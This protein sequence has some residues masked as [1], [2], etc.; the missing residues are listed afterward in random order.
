MIKVYKNFLSKEE[1]ENVREYFEFCFFRKKDTRPRPCP[2]IEGARVIYG[3]PVAD[4]FLCSKKHIVEK[5]FNKELLPTYSYTRMYYNGQALPKHKDRPACEISLT[6][7]IWQDL[8]WPIF[9]D[10]KPYSAKSG[11]CIFYE[12]PKYE[13]W[14]EPYKGET[15]CQV[16]MHYVDA[17]G[18]NTTVAYDDT[19]H[20]K[21]PKEI[22]KQWF[23]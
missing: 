5:T 18:P 16:F 3:D 6:L 20:L 9:M 10:G 14:R 1:L 21:Y 13:H 2:M 19:N 15:C 23:K 12:G 22:Y 7:N 8:E 4:Y 17:H 11:D